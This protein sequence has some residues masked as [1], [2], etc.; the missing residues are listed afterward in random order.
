MKHKV[1]VFI[2]PTLVCGFSTNDNFCIYTGPQGYLRVKNKIS[3]DL[4]KGALEKYLGIDDE[5]TDLFP[6]YI[7]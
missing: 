3:L 7:I 2:P 4:L 6:R 1:K 5:P